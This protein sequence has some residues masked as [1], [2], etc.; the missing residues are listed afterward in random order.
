MPDKPPPERGELVPRVTCAVVGCRRRVARS[1][2][3][4]GHTEWICQPHWSPIPVPRRKVYVR[5]VRQGER[6]RAAAVWAYLV[7][8][9]NAKARGLG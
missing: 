3:K 4:P 7:H 2:L 1:K 6:H 8:I 5:L 9:A